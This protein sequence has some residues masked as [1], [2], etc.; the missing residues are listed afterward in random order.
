[1]TDTRRSAFTL[2]ELLVV[3]A[4]IA[5]LIGLLLP[6]VQNVRESANRLKCQN[7]LKQ[8]GLALHNHE[9]TY[10]E[11]PQA[12]NPWPLVHSAASRLLPFV[13]QENL[14]RLVD[15]TTPP[16]SPANTQASRTRIGLF[17]RAAVGAAPGGRNLGPDGIV[18]DLL[19]DS[20]KVG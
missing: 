15:Y 14:Q 10:Q 16:T 5:I 8:I 4:I 7:N 1:M 6:A 13:E 11:F 18:P 12:R 19:V 9:G 17:V 3:I 20:G 2:I